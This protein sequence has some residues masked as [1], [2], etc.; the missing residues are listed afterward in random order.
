MDYSHGIRL[1]VVIEW[2]SWSEYV[3]VSTIERVLVPAETFQ[4]LRTPR[5]ESVPLASVWQ[6]ADRNESLTD[7]RRV[8]ATLRRVAARPTVMS[9]PPTD[10]SEKTATVR[11]VSATT[12]S[13]REKPERGE[14][15]MG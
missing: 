5:V 1:S 9:R 10:A 11:T 15:D 4:T 6:G 7:V 13:T 2:T 3:T 8:V 12:T 14:F